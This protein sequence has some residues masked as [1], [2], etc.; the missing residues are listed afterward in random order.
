MISKFKFLKNII[1][2]INPELRKFLLVGITSVLVDLII[3]YFL[4]KIGIY[5]SFAKAISFLIGTVYSY[6]FNKIWTF[7]AIGGKKI[8][9]KF[10]FV[11]LIALN[12]NIFINKF[13]IDLISFDYY[14]RIIIAFLISTIISAIF[15]FVCIKKFVF[16]R[17]VKF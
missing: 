2:K 15:N 8:F 9:F 12:I 16:K 17:R 5:I 11:Y 6:F 4:F 1:F 14:M 3:Y 7:R 13:I 10:I